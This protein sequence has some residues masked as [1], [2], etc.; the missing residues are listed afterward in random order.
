MLCE[1]TCSNDG[2]KAG[3]EVAVGKLVANNVSSDD[4]GR[5]WDP[6]EEDSNTRVRVMI[7][8]DPGRWK[9]CCAISAFSMLHS[10]HLNIKMFGYSS[11]K[12]NQYLLETCY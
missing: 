10:K 12:I 1:V 2:W 9:V 7:G 5:D 11:N 6:W 3:D 8:I 4:N